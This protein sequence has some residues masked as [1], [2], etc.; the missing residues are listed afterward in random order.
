M[1]FKFAPLSIFAIIMLFSSVNAELPTAIIQ[2]ESENTHSFTVEIARDYED[3]AQG[4]MGREALPDNTGMLFIYD[5]PIQPNFWMKN[6]L[7]PI[8]I[9]FLNEKGIINFIEKEAPPCN[10][11]NTCKH[12][13]P[14]Y[15]SKYVL[16]ITSGITDE[17]NIQIG[18]KLILS[19]DVL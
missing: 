15:K 6:M 11:E 5:T 13:T 10:E 7:I 1:F 18:D 16:E 4:L 17:L 8:D 3:K 12:Y 14:T 9:L 19:E 2:I